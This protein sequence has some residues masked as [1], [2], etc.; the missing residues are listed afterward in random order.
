LALAVQ[1]PCACGQGAA[2]FLPLTATIC[3]VA[4]TGPLDAERLGALKRQTIEKLARRPVRCLILDVTGAPAI[5]MRAAQA[6]EQIAEAAR[7]IG[8]EVILAGARAE[9]AEMLSATPR[10]SNSREAV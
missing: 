5:D 7:L 9:L 1:P 10:G 3:V 6:F 2:I 4:V 8:A